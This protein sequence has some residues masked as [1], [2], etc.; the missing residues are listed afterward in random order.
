VGNVRLE[1]STDGFGTQHVIASSTANDGTYNWTIPLDPSDTVSVRV[2]STMSA[3]ISATS[4]AAFTI[5]GPHDFEESFKKVSQANLEGGERIT[6]S[7]IL[8]EG[9]DAQMTLTDGIP[10]PYT[11]VP[12]SAEIE[13]AWKGPVQDNSGIQWSGRV[14]STVPVTITFQVQVPMTTT[15]LAVFNRAQVSRN[16]AA[17][18]EL[19][20]LSIVNGFHAYLPI[21]FR[22]Y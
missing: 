22:N 15:T 19:T 12:G 9:I 17:P 7:I 10:W 14:T 5:A 18:A 3:T 6:Y 2:S 20:A 21:A 1:Y 4:Q 8:Y 11:Y 13:P 16:G